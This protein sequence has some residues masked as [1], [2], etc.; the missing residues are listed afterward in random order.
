MMQM[1]SCEHFFQNVFVKSN[2]R[3]CKDVDIL[4]L[5]EKGCAIALTSI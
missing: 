1:L 3:G 2:I 5:P 4:L